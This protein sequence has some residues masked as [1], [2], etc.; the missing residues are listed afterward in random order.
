MESPGALYIVLPAT[1][2]REVSFI[3]PAKAKSGNAFHGKIYKIKYIKILQFAC[4][5]GIF[6]AIYEFF[7]FIPQDECIIVLF[8]V[9]NNRY[10]H[11]KTTL[12]IRIKAGKHIRNYNECNF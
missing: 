6:P 4:F 2:C 10:N 3:F 1:D 7:L 12:N 8:P 11:T 5:P 9:R